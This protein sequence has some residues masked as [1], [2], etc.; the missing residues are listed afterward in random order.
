MRHIPDLG[1]GYDS[2]ACWWGF[3]TLIGVR[4]MYDE[5]FDSTKTFS[6]REDS[7]GQARKRPR[8][9]ANPSLRLPPKPPPPSAANPTPIQSPNL[10][11][12]P[13]V[14]L[15]QGRGGEERRGEGEVVDGKMEWGIS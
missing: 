6:V 11:S 4:A 3:K 1:K 5:S 8:V 7:W 12:C 10:P 2:A 14:I 13:I 15:A 9:T